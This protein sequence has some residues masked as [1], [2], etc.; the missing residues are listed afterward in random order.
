MLTKS[1][2]VFN[3]ITILIGEAVFARC[4]SSLKTLRVEASESLPGPSS[5]YKGNK[6]RFVEAIR[7]VSIIK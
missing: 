3:C 7:C 6:K 5:H 2:V 1:T 4:L